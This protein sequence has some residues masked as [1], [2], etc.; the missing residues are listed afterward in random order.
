MFNDGENFTL[1]SLSSEFPTT[2]I[3][4]TTDCFRL[5]RTINQFRRLC[6]P[7]EQ[8]L[9]SVEDSEPTNDDDDALDE[10][11]DDADAITDDNED[12]VICEIILNADNYRLCKANAAHGAV[13][14]NI[15]A[16]LFEKTLTAVE[17]PHLDTKSLISKLEDVAKTVDLDVSTILAEEIKDPILGLVRSWLREG[18][19]PE[20]K[21]PE[22]Q[23]SKGLLGYCQEFDRLLI[24]EEGQLLCYNE[25]SDKLEV[26][27]LRICLPLSLF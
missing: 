21:S 6:L 10:L 4:S 7:S 27:N 9:S 24:E 25:P 23:P 20:A 18:I 3:Q 2:T 16:S 22:V 8:C 5:G 15:D 1:N 17:V 19:S 26:E 13:L 14:G 12:N 11:P